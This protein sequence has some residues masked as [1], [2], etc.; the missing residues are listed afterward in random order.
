MGTSAGGYHFDVSF[1][2]TWPEIL[3]AVVHRGRAAGYQ[4]AADGAEVRPRGS[5]ITFAGTRWKG[6]AQGGLRFDVL[7][8]RVALNANVV[9]H[10]G[11][12]GD[13]STYGFGLAH[14][15]LVGE[16]IGEYQAQG[17]VGVWL[18]EGSLVLLSHEGSDGE[19]VAEEMIA[20]FDV[21]DA[22]EELWRLSLGRPTQFEIVSEAELSKTY[23]CPRWAPEFTPRIR[24]LPAGVK[25]HFR[26]QRM[27]VGAHVHPI[28][29]ES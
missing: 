23:A 7:E 3:P 19:D 24:S 17:I 14:P 8:H 11:S 18:K 16:N 27:I 26:H 9:M 4:L 29:E 15:E 12:V 25:A 6:L 13:H 28:V 1:I 21:W 20:R 2:P 22:L 10:A 5:M